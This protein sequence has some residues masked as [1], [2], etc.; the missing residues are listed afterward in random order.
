MCSRAKFQYDHPIGNDRLRLIRIVGC[1]LSGSE[2]LDLV[3]E[4]HPL[5]SLPQYH[6]LSYTWG[7]PFAD[8]EPSSE[9]NLVTILVNG[10]E[11]DIFPNLHNAL[12]W[13]RAHNSCDLYW[14]DAICINQKDTMERGI[15]VGIMDC[16]Y[17]SAHR[18]DIWLGP[19][20]EGHFPAEVSKLI[21]TMADNKRASSAYIRERAF[22]DNDAL[23]RYG[24]IAVSEC[25]WYAFIAFFDRKWFNRVWVVQEVAL[26]K[27]ACVIWDDGF[28]PWETVANCCDFLYDSHLYEQLSEM[29]FDNNPTVKRVHIGSNASGI[30]AI[31]RCRHDILTGWESM[32]LDHIIG[33]PCVI[34][35]DR[36]NRSKSGG[37]LLLLMLGLTI[38]VE[39]SDPR[40]QVFGLIGILNLLLDVSGRERAELEPDY[41]ECSTAVNVFT[42]AAIFIM[43]ECKNLTL[44]TAVPDD[45][46]KKV[47]DLPS[48]VPDFAA[49]GPSA[50]LGMRWPDHERYFDAC[51]S[52][53]ALWRIEN[54]SMLHIKAFCIGS[55]TLSGE[56]YSELAVNG[57]FAQWA[58]FLMQCDPVYKPTG[59]CRVEA[60]WRTLI[61]DRDPFNH[62]APSRLQKAFHHWI[63]DHIVWEVYCALK[64]GADLMEYLANLDSMQKL[65]DSDVSKT[66]PDCGVIEK[67]LKKLQDC[68]KK[69]EV[70]VLFE[71]FRHRCQAYVNLAFETLWERRPFLTDTGYLGLGSQSLQ[72]GDSVWIVAGCPSPLALRQIP[73]ASP[74]SLVYHRIVGETYVHGIMHGEAVV[75]G[76][77]WEDI[78]IR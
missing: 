48:W 8:E 7:S 6:A 28:I 47:P 46:V 35:G 34:S 60:F 1:G 30:V 21:H 12:L 70:S 44:L 42:D 10:C 50:F 39:A 2:K 31:Q 65:A 38:G 27:D 62:P 4:E 73:V 40:D 77:L 16:I 23:K 43:E 11:F 29:L 72:V 33:F 71:G 17:K 24:L 75:E 54:D 5:T 14:V 64:K 37:A 32:T 26:S 41:R 36:S 53:P 49:N 63:A 25:V 69:E 19:V 67:Y 13:I 15:Q 51:R 22:L 74:S 55:V 57:S 58:D 52:S 56:I 76:V 45:A 59:Q 3:I 78:C 9:D 68:D 20:T 18:V 61:V 66:V